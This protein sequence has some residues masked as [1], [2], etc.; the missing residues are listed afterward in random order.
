[1]SLVVNGKKESVAAAAGS[2]VT[3]EREWKSGDT[4]E[5]TVPMS[6]HVEALPDDQNVAA[7]LYGPIVLAGDL[8]REG[9]TA[10]VRYG[11]SVPPLGK[12]RT[13]AIPAF[14]G[15]PAKMLGS[16]ERVPGRPLTFRTK[17]LAQPHDVTLVP[18]FRAADQRYTVYWKLFTP[19]QWAERKAQFAATE[20][21]RQAI[22]RNTIDFVDVSSEQSERDHAFKGERTSEAFLEGRK[23]RD[24]RDGWFSYE[25]KVDTSAPVSL[26]CTYRG[27]EGRRR[28]HDILVEGEKLATE[29]MYYHPT[30]IFDISY[31]L[32]EALLKGKSRVTVT[33]RA[34]PGSSTG[35]VLD[36][37]TV[38]PTAR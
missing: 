26:V 22:E 25:L 4:V 7:V 17:G 10:S 29:T 19:P 11:P 5:V 32:P 14:V 15:D 9:L 37:R 18:F 6:L 27:S 28:A 12:L 1:M 30:E 35:G 36:V 13:P 33:F 16:I 20:G 31:A 34:A 21:K 38:K 24:A 8:G 2:Y 3:V 23:W